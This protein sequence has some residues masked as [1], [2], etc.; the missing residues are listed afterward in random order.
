MKQI[1]YFTLKKCYNKTS[2]GPRVKVLVLM[3]G[4]VRISSCLSVD[5]LGDLVP[6]LAASAPLSPNLN[7]RSQVQSSF[8]SPVNTQMQ[9][10]PLT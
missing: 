1:F 4:D 3:S 2:T 10:K 5:G 6:S 9:Q 7:A 8:D